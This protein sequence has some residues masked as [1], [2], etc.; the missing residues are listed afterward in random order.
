MVILALKLSLVQIIYQIKR[1]YPIL[2]LDDVF[3]ELDSNHRSCLLR[4]LPNSIQ[5]IITTTDLR[6]VN[7]IRPQDVNIINI[8]KGE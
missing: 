4:L 5:T 1:E 7:S 6:E 8:K 3:S 2:L